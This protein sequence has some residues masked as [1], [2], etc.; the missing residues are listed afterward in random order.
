MINLQHYVIL[1]FSTFSKRLKP[2]KMKG[3]RK[4]GYPMVC[5]ATNKYVSNYVHTYFWTEDKVR[6]RKMWV[7]ISTKTEE[8][9]E[10]CVGLWALHRTL[11]QWKLF[12]FILITYHN[13]NISITSLAELSTPLFVSPSNYFLEVKAKRLLN[14]I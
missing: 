1:K 3:H 10:F 12:T 6:T 7:L 5:L 11:H 8:I 9:M 13:M 2:Y 14:T 4:L